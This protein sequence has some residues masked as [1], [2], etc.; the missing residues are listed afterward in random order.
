MDEDD[1][2]DEAVEFGAEFVKR[3]TMAARQWSSG[4]TS[5]RG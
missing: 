5:W 4:R 3:M 2:D 1:D